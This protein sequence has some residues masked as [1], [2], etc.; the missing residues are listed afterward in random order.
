MSEATSQAGGRSPTKKKK[1]PPNK[2]LSLLSYKKD[3]LKLNEVLT[4]SYVGKRILLTS[5]YLYGHRVPE[6]EEDLLFQYHVSSI[7]DDNKG[8]GDEDDED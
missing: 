8:K 5:Q 3:K 7:N 2:Q 6:G 4:R 1:K